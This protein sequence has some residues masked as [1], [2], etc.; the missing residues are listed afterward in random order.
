[1]ARAKLRQQ[2]FLKAVGLGI[3]GWPAGLIATAV[4][5]GIA[6]AVIRAAWHALATIGLARLALTAACVVVAWVCYRQYQRLPPA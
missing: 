3:V 4:V 6:T 1:V 5:I 2:R